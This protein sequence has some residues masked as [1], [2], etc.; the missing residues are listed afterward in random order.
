MIDINEDAGVVALNASGLLGLVASAD[1]QRAWRAASADGG[2]IRGFMM[3][4]LL[5]DSNGRAWPGGVVGVMSSSWSEDVLQVAYPDAE[6]RSVQVVVYNHR[7]QWEKEFAE[8]LW[9]A[10][11]D[12]RATA[13]MQSLDAHWATV[14]TE[15]IPF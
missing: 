13:I 6:R 14:R 10:V 4:D 8:A 11:A 9:G 2:S 15:D 3:R 12:A 5:I 1:A 7:G